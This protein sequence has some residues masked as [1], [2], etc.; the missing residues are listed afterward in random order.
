MALAGFE[1]PARVSVKAVVLPFNKFP[2]LMPVLGP[3]MQSTGEAMGV[4]LTFQAALA[5][6]LLGAGSPSPADT[7]ATQSEPML[8]EGRTV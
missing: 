6:A 7:L 5:K 1:P 4:G 3:E 2:T 8:I